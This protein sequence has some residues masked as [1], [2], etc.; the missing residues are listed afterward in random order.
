MPA[1]GRCT[2]EGTHELDASMMDGRTRNAGA[3]A[4]VQRV[5]HPISLARQVLENSPM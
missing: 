3:V 4:G 5:K 2:H 1:K